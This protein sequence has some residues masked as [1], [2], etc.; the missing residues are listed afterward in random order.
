MLS[1]QILT[2]PYGVITDSLGVFLGGFLG[3]LLKNKLPHKLRSSLPV[4]FGIVSMA[5]GVTAIQKVNCFP[6]VVLAVIAGYIL[7][8]I[9]G[10]EYLVNQAIIK[11]CTLIVKDNNEKED[12]TSYMDILFGIVPL[13]CVSGTG[14]FGTMHSRFTG[15]HSILFVKTILDFCTSMMFGA[16]LGSI[17]SFIAIPQFCIMAIVFF[18]SGF[19]LPITT[20]EMLLDFTACGGIIMLATGLRISQIKSISTSNL[21]PSFILVMPLSQLYRWFLG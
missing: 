14:I 19:L 13:F 4:I 2:I 20:S 11:I 8:T 5:M 21:L 9:L 7:G 3:C 12:L 16:L 17:V 6:A 1:N 10:L 15:D 18:I